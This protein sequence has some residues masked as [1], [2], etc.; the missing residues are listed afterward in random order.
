MECRVSQIRIEI[1]TVNEL[2]EFDIATTEY[3]W[4]LG[5]NAQ[6]IGKQTRRGNGNYTETHNNLF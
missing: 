4:W 5:R 2:I 6:C 3:N 1:K